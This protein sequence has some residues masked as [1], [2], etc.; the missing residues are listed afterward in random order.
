[1][2][3]PKIKVTKR[4]PAPSSNITG[5]GGMS[6]AQAL[7][8]LQNS[9]GQILKDV[10]KESF[11]DKQMTDILT[12]PKQM[13]KIIPAFFAGIMSLEKMFV[14]QDELNLGSRNSLI[15]LG[16]GKSGGYGGH[17]I[18]GYLQFN[19]EMPQ[20]TRPAMDP[21][22][23]PSDPTKNK[24]GRID[25]SSNKKFIKVSQQAEANEYEFLKAFENAPAIAQK[26]VDELKNQNKIN[27]NDQAAFKKI[28]DSYQKVYTNK[29]KEFFSDSDE[30]QKIL[31]KIT[32]RK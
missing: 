3:G 6:Q 8:S 26:F 13:E 28:V 1:M 20:P 7:G 14:K 15:G 4:P 29:L 9:K 25:I 30:G 11:T 27:P 17:P 10:L 32:P 24:P 12:D 21:T 2:S 31:G 18:E 19:P 16:K 22:K 23:D 5:T